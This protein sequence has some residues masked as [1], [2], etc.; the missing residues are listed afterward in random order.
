MGF[1]T[2][3]GLLLNDQLL[4]VG[5][6]I[7]AGCTHS[8]LVDMLRGATEVVE[9]LVLRYVS[10]LYIYTNTYIHIHIFWKCLSFGDDIALDSNLGSQREATGNGSWGRVSVLI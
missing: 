10:A 5:G 8:E 2:L 1:C 9:L 4:Q 3:K 6:N 7:L